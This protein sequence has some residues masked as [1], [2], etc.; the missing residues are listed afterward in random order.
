MK[1]RGFSL[2]ELLVSIAVIGVLLGMLLPAIQ[3]VRETAARMSCASNLRQLGIAMHGYHSLYGIMVPAAIDSGHKKGSWW[4]MAPMPEAG[5]YGDMPYAG[6]NHSGFTLLLPYI[7]HEALFLKY[8]LS[9]PSCNVLVKS[10]A[11]T[12]PYPMG[13]PVFPTLANLPNGVDATPN[14]DVVGEYI[15]AYRCPSDRDP[16][17][18]SRPAPLLE[19]PYAKTNARRSNYMFSCA[20]Y[21]ES[22]ERT[23]P[24]TGTYGQ[25]HG[26]NGHNGGA[27]LGRM[28][29]VGTTSYTG[30]IVEAKQLHLNDTATAIDPDVG[31]FWGAACLGA[32]AGRS[33]GQRFVIGMMFP[34][35]DPAMNINYPYCMVGGIPADDPLGKYQ[36]RAGAGS[37]HPGGV[38][39][40][41]ADG[42]V[43]FVKELIPYTTYVELTKILKTFVPDDTYL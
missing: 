23:Y 25:R 36:A 4:S 37:W 27:I 12:P 43:L 11:T 31:P 42:S 41:M 1:R 39:M 17:V 19:D 8:D 34:Q 13:G 14:A 3:K 10:T 9:K 40:L 2:L 38:N 29:E 18:V 16:D 30:M 6:L 28:I 32:V 22:A 21:D 26:I 5:F 33:Y 35:A 15:A 7:E 20:G 24:M